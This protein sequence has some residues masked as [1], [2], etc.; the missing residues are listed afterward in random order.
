MGF[1]SQYGSNT[2]DPITGEIINTQTGARSAPSPQWRLEHAPIRNIQPIDPN[3]LEGFNMYRQLATM[4]G[5]SAFG[6]AAQDQV[7]FNRQNDLEAA[8]RIPRSTL[9]PR[10]GSGQ[11]ER[12]AMLGSNAALAA[13]QGATS[14]AGN[15]LLNVLKQDQALKQQALGRYSDLQGKYATGRQN[16]ALDLY[17][18]DIN[19]FAATQ[20]A[21]AIDPSRFSTTKQYA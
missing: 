9:S 8:S 11:R 7:I 14:D 19:R 17:E 16:L 2:V 10:A 6:R 1:T 3:K 5:P 12:A 20:A 4:Q 13:K 15:R 18:Q 21:A